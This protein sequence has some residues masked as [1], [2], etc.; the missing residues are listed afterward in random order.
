MTIQTAIYLPM[1]VTGVCMYSTVDSDSELQVQ[2]LE[3]TIFRLN[4][5][6]RIANSLCS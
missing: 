1:S 5:R 2:Y 4:W 3:G 6:K